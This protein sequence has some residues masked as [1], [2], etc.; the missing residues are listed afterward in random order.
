[1]THPIRCNPHSIYGPI[2]TCIAHKIHKLYHSAEPGRKLW[3]EN[4]LK[5]FPD[6]LS[7]KLDAR[8]HTCVFI[9][10]HTSGALHN[11]NCLWQHISKVFLFFVRNKSERSILRMPVLDSLSTEKFNVFPKKK[12]KRKIELQRIFGLKNRSTYFVLRRCR[13]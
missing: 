10:N 3:T 8:C 2:R 9:L 4:S 5:H 6:Y 13:N 1:M 12:K 7:T 11:E